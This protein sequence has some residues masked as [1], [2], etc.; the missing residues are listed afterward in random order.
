MEHRWGERIGVD[1]PVR[2]VSHA[3]RMRPARLANLSVSGALIETDWELRPLSQI[4]VIIDLPHHWRYEA[5]TVAAYVARRYKRGVGIEWCEFAP[6]VISK[7]LRSL[8]GRRYGR[9]R[10]PET[11]AAIVISRLSPPLLK[12]GT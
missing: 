1:M 4:E 9:L 3:Y 2:V 12:H 5:P 7:T 6:P 10:K 8:A 11:P